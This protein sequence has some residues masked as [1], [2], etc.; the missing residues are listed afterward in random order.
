MQASCTHTSHPYRHGTGQLWTLQYSL[1]KPPSDVCLSICLYSYAQRRRETCAPEPKALPRQA[2]N[3]VKHQ[4][5][6]TGVGNHGQRYPKHIKTIALRLHHHSPRCY[7]ELRGIFQLPSPMTLQRHLK[8]SL[9]NF[10]VQ[11]RKILYY[12]VLNFNCATST[13]NNVCSFFH[14][15]VSSMAF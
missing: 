2:E 12:E 9:G 7:G 8:A 5:A 13:I 15:L 10:E 1:L 4:L 11:V 6:L 14:S 3:F